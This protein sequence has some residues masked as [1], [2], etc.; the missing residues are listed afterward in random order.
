MSR[1]RKT[2]KC[3]LIKGEMTGGGGGGLAGATRGGGRCKGGGGK[4]SVPAVIFVVISVMAA[5]S[6]T[7]VVL[8][9]A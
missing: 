3:W 6:V 7:E 1:E 9:F 8:S 4:G 5:I 2:K